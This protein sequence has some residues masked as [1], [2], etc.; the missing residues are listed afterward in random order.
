M[1]QILVSI[2]VTAGTVCPCYSFR[3]NYDIFDNG[4][5][6]IVFAFDPD[7]IPVQCGQFGDN[8]ASSEDLRAVCIGQ[9]NGGL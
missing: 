9:V 1:E 7:F 6:I 8:G 5:Q 4:V 2:V 3:L